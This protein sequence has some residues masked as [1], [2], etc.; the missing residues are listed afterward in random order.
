MRTLAVDTLVGCEGDNARGGRCEPLLLTLHGEPVVALVQ[1]SEPSED[2][3]LLAVLQRGGGREG[4]LVLRFEYR[5][6]AGEAPPPNAG[7]SE[8]SEHQAQPD[9]VVQAAR[10]GEQ[11]LVIYVDAKQRTP[12]AADEETARLC[13]SPKFRDIIERSRAR[14]RAEGGISSE[15]IRR[16]LGASEPH[17]PD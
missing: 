14:Y 9:V 4:V 1:G 17:G 16:R 11:G 2:P 7:D 15:E 10:E 3:E 5:S 8:R 12:S 13:A 6:S